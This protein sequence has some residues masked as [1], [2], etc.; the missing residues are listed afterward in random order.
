MPSATSRA[1]D[2]VGMTSGG[3][4]L[5]AQPH[6]GALP[7]CRSMFRGAA[8]SAFSRS[9]P[10]AMV[11][12][13]HLSSWSRHVGDVGMKPPT[14]PGRRRR[15]LWRTSPA[16]C[17][18]TQRGQDRTDVRGAVRRVDAGRRRSTPVGGSAGPVGGRVTHQDPEPA[19]RGA[20]RRRRSRPRPLAVRSSTMPFDDRQAPDRRRGLG[21]VGPSGARRPPAPGEVEH[22]V[23]LTPRRCRRTGRARSARRRPGPAG[24]RIST[25]PSAGCTGSRS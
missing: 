14:A 13:A 21:A 24:P 10:P 9:P 6:H 7:N 8:S 12:F 5:V 11:T 19:T 20:R 22:L 25:E 18:W 15:L 17:L 16:S 4:G 23:H 2:P 3:A 1:I